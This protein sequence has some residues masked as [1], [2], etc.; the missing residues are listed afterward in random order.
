DLI[1]TDDLQAADQ[2]RVAGM[3]VGAVGGA[4]V[5]LDV[6]E[7]VGRT[8]HRQ[9]ALVV[10]DDA[11]PAQLGG[12]APIAVA[13]ELRR[14]R[15]DGVAQGEIGGAVALAL[16]GIAAACDA[17]GATEQAHRPGRIRAVEGGDHRALLPEREAGQLKAFFNTASPIACWPT[18]RSRSAIRTASPFV[19]LGSAKSSGARSTTTLRHWPSRS[20]PTSCSRHSCA[21]V[22]SPRSNS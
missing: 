16:V 10:G 15:L 3:A 12:D 7:E 1:G 11:P 17:E 5:L 6:D 8:H 4:A 19:A 22:F 21:I 20:A 9:H 18:R 14:D 2:V 13:G